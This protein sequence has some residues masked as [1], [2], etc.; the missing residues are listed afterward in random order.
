MMK[1]ELLVPTIMKALT[2][3]HTGYLGEYGKDPD[4]RTPKSQEFFEARNTLL[5][6]LIFNDALTNTKIDGEEQLLP[7]LDFVKYMYKLIYDKTEILYT[8]TDDNLLA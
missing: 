4:D 3:L 6:Y 1:I 2:T 5:S 8:A 7:Y